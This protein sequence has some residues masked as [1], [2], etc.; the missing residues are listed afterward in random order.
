MLS[1]LYYILICLGFVV[2]VIVYYLFFLRNKEIVDEIIKQE[3]KPTFFDEETLNIFLKR[4]GG[5]Q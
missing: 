3:L 1:N 4:F 5:K 2:F